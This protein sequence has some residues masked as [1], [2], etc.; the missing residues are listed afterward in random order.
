[1]ST[2]APAGL[3]GLRGDGSHCSFAGSTVGS[4]TPDGG[5]EHFRI[6]R[7]VGPRRSQETS[8][9]FWGPRPES[10]FWVREIVVGTLMVVLVFK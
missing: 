1:M 10:G 2:K 5:W 9:S 4:R 7:V 8:H 3:G 6:C